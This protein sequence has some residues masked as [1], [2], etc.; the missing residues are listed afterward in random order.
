MTIEA[1]QQTPANAPQASSAIE[2]GD[3]DTMREREPTRL[4]RPLPSRRHA[5]L[6]SSFGRHTARAMLA[7]ES[8]MMTQSPPHS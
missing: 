7:I 5:T 2:S 4:A 1:S 3:D 8:A 6:Y